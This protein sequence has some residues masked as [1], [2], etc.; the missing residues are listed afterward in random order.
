VFKRNTNEKLHRKKDFTE[1]LRSISKRGTL[2]LV[3]SA[4]DELHN[5]AVA[6]KEFLEL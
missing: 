2:T 5:Q 3:Y 4:R 1:K 6:L